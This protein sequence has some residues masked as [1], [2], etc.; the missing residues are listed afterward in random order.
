VANRVDWLEDRAHWQQRTRE[1]EDRLSDALHELLTQRFVDQRAVVLMDRL[2][3]GVRIEAEMSPEGELNAAG[4]RLG[5]L[6][7][8]TFQVDQAPSA[9]GAKAVRKAVRQAVVA[10]L[11]ERVALA[12]AAPHQDLRLDASGRV[13]HEDGQLAKLAA[14]VDVLKPSVRPMSHELLNQRQRDALRR[15]A[16]AWVRE[17]VRRLTAP[18]DAPEG[19]SPAMVG[20]LYRVKLG[21]GTLRRRDAHDLIQSLSGAERKALARQD[22]RVGMHAVY[23]LPL[24]KPEMVAR[25][26]WL[27]GVAREMRT[28]L[29]PPPASATSVP[30]EHTADFYEAVGYRLLGSRAVRVDM[31]ERLDAALRGR[32]REKA[33]PLPDVAMSWLGCSFEELIDVCRALGYL[34]HGE[35]DKARVNRPENTH[36][37]KRKRRRPPRRRGMDKKRR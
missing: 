25:R 3:S 17:E 34:V 9:A 22:V 11:A 7:G 36:R 16:Q 5:W 24:L 14:G 29:P 35:G 37:S 31:V 28:L 30:A 33:S 4:V 12:V 8:F 19:V 1:I 27:W 13:C 26:A 15:R 32:T 23:S 21:L 2:E 20:I 6:Q 18:L 10:P